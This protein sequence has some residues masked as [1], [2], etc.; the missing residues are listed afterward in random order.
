MI[1]NKQED[2]RVNETFIQMTFSLEQKE[3]GKFTLF[4]YYSLMRGQL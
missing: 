3:R 4:F 2:N 1:K